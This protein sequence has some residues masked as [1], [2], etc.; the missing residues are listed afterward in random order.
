MEPITQLS[1]NELKA[2]DSEHTSSPFE[3]TFANKLVEVEQIFAV[4]DLRLK[5][6][7]ILL[8]REEKEM[9]LRQDEEDR[10]LRMNSFMGD[11]SNY[12]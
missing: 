5:I 1:P 10:K 7:Q 11:G 3:A 12:R 9:R 2:M 8:E 4:Q 6:G